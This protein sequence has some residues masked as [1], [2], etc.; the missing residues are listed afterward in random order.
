MPSNTVVL[1]DQHMTQ[2]GTMTLSQRETGNNDN[3]GVL[4]T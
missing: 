2:T 1:F 3:E 4:Q